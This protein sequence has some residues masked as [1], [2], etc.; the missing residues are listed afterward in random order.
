MP[1]ENL[2]SSQKQGQLFYERLSNKLDPKHKLYQLRS[3]IDWD[4]LEKE[5]LANVDVKQFGRNRKSHRV[6]LGLFMLQAMYNGSD[7]FTE[8]MLEENTYWQ[9]F[10]GYE[11]FTK[12]LGVSEATIRRFR[13]LIGEAG[14]TAIMKELVRIGIK[15]GALKKKDLEATIVDT[16]VQNKN[17]KHPHDAHLMEDARQ[18]IVKLCKSLGISLNETYAKEYKLKTMQLWKYSKDSKVKKR[19]KTLKRLKTLLGRLIRVCDR[20][21]DA[22][23][24]QLSESQAS[25]LSKAT[26][27]QTNSLWIQ[28]YRG[29]DE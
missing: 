11:Y 1:I 25:V 14:C 24:L 12:N 10:C 22:L 16:T 2:S 26:P 8:E 17:I 5:A 19:W 13:T 27:I 9:Y 29:I 20:N 23:D 28:N 3:L 18:N 15:T 6:M 7:N 21:I 4:K